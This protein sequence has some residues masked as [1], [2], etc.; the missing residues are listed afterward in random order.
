LKFDFSTI[1]A[2]ID[3]YKNFVWTFD[4]FFARN[5]DGFSV[6][7]ISCEKENF[8]K[9]TAVSQQ[10]YQMFGYSPED[11]I[12]YDM[13]VLVPDIIGRKHDEYLMNYIENSRSLSLNS[14]NMLFAKTLAGFI[15]PMK[16]FVKPSPI[17]DQG[18]QHEIMIKDRI[19]MVGMISAL[20]THEEYIMFDENGY[21]EE[22]SES[23]F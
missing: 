23:T 4:P 12:N 8:S 7:E 19:R 18:Y 13:K 22:I 17:L 10:F 5:I 2:K 9:I 15:F 20:K 3:V 21:I 14:M 6:V 16:I 1:K 11:K